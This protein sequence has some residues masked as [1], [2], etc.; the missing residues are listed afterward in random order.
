MARARNEALWNAARSFFTTTDV[1]TVRPRVL[2]TLR[3]PHPSPLNGLRVLRSCLR[4]KASV[5]GYE[6]RVRPCAPDG[7]LRGRRSNERTISKMEWTRV[8]TTESL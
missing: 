2:P 4:C 3:C 5:R 1:A 6:Q 8:V 7:Q